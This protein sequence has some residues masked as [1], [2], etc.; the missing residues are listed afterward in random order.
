MVNAQLP[1]TTTPKYNFP[2]SNENL[3]LPQQLI[4]L[5]IQSLK[6]PPTALPT[7]L[8]C[9]PRTS[10][11]HQNSSPPEAELIKL[12]PNPAR[13]PI[14]AVDVASMT[15]G[16]TERGTLL[17]VRGAIVWKPTNHYRYL[18]LGP[19]PFHITEIHHQEL[20]NALHENHRVTFSHDY[21]LP[22]VL[23][24]Q[25]KLTALLERWIQTFVNHAFH[26]SLM[27]WDG[28]LTASTLGTS[29]QAMRRLLKEA[30]NRQNTILAFS[31]MTRVLQHG[32]RITDLVWQHPAPCL[33]KIE[34]PSF[35]GSLCFLGR[36]YVA[37][38]TNGALAF[39][40]DAD[41]DLPEEQAV[42]GVQK[43]LGND[44]VLQSYPETL[45][46]A[47]ILSTFTANEVIG[48]QRYIAK[49][50]HIK[51]VTRPN[52]RRLLFGRFGKGPEG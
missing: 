39:R 40:M 6:K 41:R 21:I 42:E 36:M 47:H 28:S 25:T 8:Q 38:L 10:A 5:S 45:R 1:I 50:R 24:A 51:L 30:G 4:E 23:H 49:E 9:L 2:L 46:L 11:L 3:Q 15:I 16:E 22:N 17:A 12:T 31:K 20:R 33:L 27:L 43:L 14:V 26:D 35:A 44:L 48:L 13:T 7:T 34:K 19:F 32:T 37:K 52:V 29:P 18:R